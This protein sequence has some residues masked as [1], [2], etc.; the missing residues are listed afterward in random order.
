MEFNPLR[1]LRRLRLHL[2][3]FFPSCYLDILS[4]C[5]APQVR[6]Q[7]VSRLLVHFRGIDHD[8]PARTR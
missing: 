3:T 5:Q 4:R 8:R 7:S 1:T 2:R 6:R